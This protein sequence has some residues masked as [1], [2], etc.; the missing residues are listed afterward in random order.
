MVRM[1]LWLIIDATI[2]N[3]KK[4]APVPFPQGSDGE[5]VY[6]NNKIKEIMK[7][8]TKLGSLLQSY[9]INPLRNA[10]VHTKYRIEKGF[11]YKTDK[12]NWKMSRRQVGQSGIPVS[13]KRVSLLSKIL[14]PLA[15]NDSRVIRFL[16]SPDRLW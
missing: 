9:Y 2:T 4:F 7:E 6:P 11:L 1:L 13:P 16:A 12:K 8:N 15:I 5:P 14:C 10:I 3:G